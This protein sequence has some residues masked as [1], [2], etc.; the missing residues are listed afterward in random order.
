MRQMNAAVLVY[1]YFALNAA[2]YFTAVVKVFSIM[3]LI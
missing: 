1:H 2:L 3:Q